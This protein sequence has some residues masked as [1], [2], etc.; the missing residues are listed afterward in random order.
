MPCGN[1][2]S[3]LNKTHCDIGAGLFT[4]DLLLPA[5]TGWACRNKK[6]EQLNVSITIEVKS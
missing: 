3:Y 4:C 5:L 6:K 1:N 2:S